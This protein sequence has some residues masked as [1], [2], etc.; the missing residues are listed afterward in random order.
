[1]GPSVLIRATTILTLVLIALASAIPRHAVVSRYNPVRNASSSTT[2][3]QVGNGF[4]AF[5]ADISG[6]QTF[7][8]WAIMSDWGWKNDIL[9]AGV[10]QE[11]VLTYRG[12]VW[13]GV[14][15]EFGGPAAPQQWLIANPNRVNLGRIGLLYMD[16]V[17]NGQ[18]ITEADL[19]DARQ[20]LDLWS[21]TITSTFAVDGYNVT[22]KT[23]TAQSS[24]TVGIA[25]HSTLVQDGRLGLFLDFPW[26]DGSQK[27]QA[28]YVG[29]WNDTDSHT[30]A[31]TAGPGLGENVLWQ[32][33]HTMSAASFYTTLG[34]GDNF[35]TSRVS[36]TTHKYRLVPVEPS[37]SFSIAVGYSPSNSEGV[38]SVAEIALE[39]ISSWKSYWSSSGFV[40]VISG[41]TDPRAD[42][43]QRRIILSRYLMRVNEAGFTPPQEVR[44]NCSEN[45]CGRKLI[46]S[47]SQAWW[48]TD[49]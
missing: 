28:P 6:L 15:Y 16:G 47:G 46:R 23:Y 35:T 7:Q 8:P 29:Y 25:I 24:S 11:D 27:F 22:V 19:S 34:G 5:G 21:G 49:G 30:T 18:N 39:S 38:P 32:I 48:M 4:F 44:C 17:G 3:M 41:S 1:M 33:N 2:P 36:P 42:E 43:L 37:S 10:T 45:Q 13:D 12:V 9:P 14:Q 26:N 31:L 40:D 20:E